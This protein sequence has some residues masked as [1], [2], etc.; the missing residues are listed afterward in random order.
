MTEPV[1]MTMHRDMWLQLVQANR[2]NARKGDPAAIRW[3]IEHDAPKAMYLHSLRVA[4]R[5][6]EDIH[7]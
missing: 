7:D 2:D 6:A 1:Y 3:V 5:N 4:R